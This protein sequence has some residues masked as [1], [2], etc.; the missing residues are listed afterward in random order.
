MLLAPLLFPA[1]WYCT[2]V[3]LMVGSNYFLC[4]G[5]VGVSSLVTLMFLCISPLSLL[6]VALPGLDW[7]YSVLLTEIPNLD[8]PLEVG[9]YDI[10]QLGF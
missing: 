10:T 5:R 3:L 2:G 9:T 4:S 7:E 1:L 8:V 6:M